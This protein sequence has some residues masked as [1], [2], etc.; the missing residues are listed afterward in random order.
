[1]IRVGFDCK[2]ESIFVQN[3]NGLFDPIL[4][5][6][7]FVDFLFSSGLSGSFEKFFEEKIFVLGRLLLELEDLNLDL[8]GSVELAD[9]RGNKTMKKIKVK[10]F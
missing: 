1:L 9:L 8:S 4:F 6:Q 2:Y 10:H 3:V 7:Q 5:G